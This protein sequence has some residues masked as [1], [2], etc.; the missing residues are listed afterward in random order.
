M[1]IIFLSLVLIFSFSSFTK[2]ISKC[3]K[4]IT[5]LYPVSVGHEKALS[6]CQQNSEADLICASK[7]AQRHPFSLSF[8]VAIMLC[9]QYSG[10]EI[11]CANKLTQQYPVSIEFEIA[12]KQC[13][14]TRL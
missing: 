14:K 8:E 2:S 13:T 7:I 10:A 4:D 6:L 9:K 3:A 11:R 1:K 5:Q 12:I